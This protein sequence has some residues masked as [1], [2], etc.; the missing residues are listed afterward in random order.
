MEIAVS[1]FIVWNGFRNRLKI[2]VFDVPHN[3]VLFKQ[4]LL[5]C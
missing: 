3:I 1:R 2:F 5:Q 4:I